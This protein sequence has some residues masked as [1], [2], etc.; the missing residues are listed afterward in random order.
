MAYTVTLTAEQEAILKW[1]GAT[2]QALVDQKLQDYVGA[3]NEA[4][5]AEK[6]RLYEVIEKSDPVEVEATIAKAKEYLD[7]QAVVAE[8]EAKLEEEIK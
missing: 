5:K 8:A 4:M 1:L 7:A 6:V 3:Y 2:P